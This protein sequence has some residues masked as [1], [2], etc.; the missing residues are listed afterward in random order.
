MPE[1]H[2]PELA[3]NLGEKLASQPGVRDLIGAGNELIDRAEDT[4]RRLPRNVG[5]IDQKIRIIGGLTLL[6]AAPFVPLNRNWKI[7][8]GAIGAA[9]ALSGSTRYCPVW[10]ATGVDTND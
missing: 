9:A 2:T 6:A 4:L 5:D 1:I 10:Q 8:F 7:A 3:T